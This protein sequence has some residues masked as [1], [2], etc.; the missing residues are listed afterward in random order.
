[1][2]TVKM[3]RTL[4]P[5]AMMEEIVVMA[6]SINNIAQNANVKNSCV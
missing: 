1:M 4:K 3:L 2:A 5:V 6:M